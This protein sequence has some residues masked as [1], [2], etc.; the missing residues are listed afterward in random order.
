MLYLLECE[1]AQFSYT[2]S[3]GYFEKGGLICP[4]KDQHCMLMLV[5]VT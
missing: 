4:S 5:I 1:E 2:L 3:H